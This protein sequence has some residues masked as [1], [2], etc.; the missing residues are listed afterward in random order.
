MKCRNCGKNN[1]RDAVFCGSCG[2]RLSVAR[3]CRYC[4]K[5]NVPD[6]KYCGKCGKAL[7]P[8]STAQKHRRSKLFLV[9]ACIG[10]VVCSLFIGVALLIKKTGERNGLTLEADEIYHVAGVP[11]DIRFSVRSEKDDEIYLCEPSEKKKVGRMHDDGKDGDLVADDQIYTY[12][13]TVDLQEKGTKQFFAQADGS[14]SAP[15]SIYSFERPTEEE[16]EEMKQD[17]CDVQ[18]AIQ[19]I[20]TQYADENGYI[21]P[22]NVKNIMENV[23][24]S[25]K[26]YKSEG[27]ILFYEIEGQSI[28][29]KFASGLTMMYEP[30]QPNVSS[31]GDEV[32][33]SF[34]SY[35]PNPDIAT[36]EIEAHGQEISK[37]LANCSYISNYAGDQVTLELIKTLPEDEVVFW[38]GHG[39]YGPIVKSFL[40]SGEYFDWDAWWWDWDYYVDCVSDRIIRRSTEKQADLACVTSKFIQHYCGDLSNSLIML[41]SCHSAQ[42]DRLAQAFIDKGADAVLGFTDTVYTS[43]CLNICDDAM[44]TMTSL[45]AATD[46]YYTLEEAVELAK[47]TYGDDD[48][49]WGEQYGYSKEERAE[50]RII[51][52]GEYQLASMRTVD[53]SLQDSMDG[54]AIADAHVIAEDTDGNRYEATYQHD[55]TYRLKMPDGPYTLQASAKN[56]AQ[57]QEP[58]IISEDCSLEMEM[59]PGRLLRVW[60]I[61]ESSG[62]A[63]ENAMVEYQSGDESNGIATD[64]D[65][66]AEVWIPLGNYEVQVTLAG[67]IPC[68]PVGISVAKD[69]DDYEIK[70]PLKKRP[71]LTGTYTG[72]YEASQGETGVTLEIVS[73]DTGIFSFYNLPGHSNAEEG[74]YQVTILYE[75]G[76]IRLKGTQWMDKPSTYVFVTFC[77]TLSADGGQ[78]VGKVDS[79]ENW[80]FELTKTS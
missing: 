67:Y 39:G 37:R 31:G 4:G 78:F 58:V 70:I 44:R 36:D 5:I 56:Y 21:E 65:G 33:L 10:I 45:N 52:T 75:D 3:Q 64:A 49:E 38:N 7:P 9:A 29:M 80:S 76:L 42:E 35:Q 74:S 60:V 48:L 41:A 19:E 30:L 59:R 20:E 61:D 79:N 22:D 17:Y 54:E 16:K 32:A 13:M 77:G 71:T 73:E 68:D 55:A 40:C 50:P 25:A 34:F 47:D 72:R 18:Q 1:A 26:K 23:A 62:L 46:D 24:S 12:V 53:V 57:M 66:K 27:I 14:N 15:V 63:L 6:A 8:D 43:Y 11:G 69:K 2:Q 28:Y 51:G